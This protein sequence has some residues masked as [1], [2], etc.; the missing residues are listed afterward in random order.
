MKYYIPRLTLSDTYG[1]YLCLF[2]SSSDFVSAKSARYQG[3]HCQ[4]SEVNIPTTVHQMTNT[5]TR[6]LTSNRIISELPLIAIDSS[7]VDFKIFSEM[8]D[9]SGY[10]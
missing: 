5:T 10:Y 4:T 6:G 8:L 2:T 1:L 7:T 9:Q 3:N